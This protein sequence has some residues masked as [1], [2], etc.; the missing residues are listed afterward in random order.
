MVNTWVSGVCATVANVVH[1]RLY[2]L[3]CFPSIIS[4][5]FLVRN[6]SEWQRGA[7][8]FGS[9]NSIRNVTRKL[10]IDLCI[11]SKHHS[12]LIVG[13]DG[14]VLC[15]DCQTPI[16]VGRGG[17][18]NYD[19]QHYN[20]KQCAENR[21]KTQRKMKRK[22][23]MRTLETFYSKKIASP[24]V[25]SMVA[26]PSFVVPR[27]PVRTSVPQQLSLNTPHSSS[28]TASPPSVIACPKALQLLAD[29]RS[30]AARL[31]CTIPEG[32]DGDILAQFAVEPPVLDAE[33]AWEILDPK[34]NLILGYGTT[35]T[36]VVE[37]LRRGRKGIEGL[38][39]YIEG[40]VRKSGVVGALL[41]GKMTTL[42][43]AMKLA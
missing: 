4:Y 7:N 43:E 37:S 10:N 8:R 33:D 21:A 24:V 13:D 23:G 22:T 17:I 28:S 1:L 9:T 40:F 26:S 42:T 3:Y 15:P 6:D 12:G 2:Y 5:L 11:Q 36:Q 19:A 38:L 25:S 31:P 29:A 39:T 20:S 18:R 27:A 32:V 41:E 16:G 35:P 30:Q 14:K 34:L